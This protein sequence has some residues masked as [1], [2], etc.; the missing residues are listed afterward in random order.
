MHTV[1]A[2]F[3]HHSR[4]LDLLES[5][6]VRAGADDAQ[7]T[8]YTVAL[9]FTAGAEESAVEAARRALDRIGATGIKIRGHKLNPS[10]KA[11]AAELTSQNGGPAE[12]AA[13]EAAANLMAKI[14]M[15]VFGHP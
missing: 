12:A 3:H 7:I 9:T 13:N 8:G 1:I 15:G 11:L 6:L 14:E 4:D 5:D 2:R 10:A